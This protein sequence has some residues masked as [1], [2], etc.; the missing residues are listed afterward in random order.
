MLAHQLKSERSIDW[1]C[2]AA[3]PVR[4][5]YFSIAGVERQ[6]EDQKSDAM[7]DQFV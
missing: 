3:I 1:W 5:E 6:K 2:R 4:R 7:P